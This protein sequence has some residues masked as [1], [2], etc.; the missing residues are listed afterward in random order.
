MPRWSRELLRRFRGPPRVAFHPDY[1]LPLPSFAARTGADARRAELALDA[2]V[3]LGVIGHDEVIVPDPCRWDDLARV[4]TPAWLDALA[5]PESLAAVFAAEPAEVP[6]TVLTS[7]RRVTGGTIAAT[8]AAIAAGGPAVNLGGGFHH[9]RRDRGVAY[10]AVNDVA[11]AVAVARAEGFDGRVVVLD[12]DAHPP[13]GIADCLGGTAWI[14]SVSGERW[15]APPG[16]QEVVVPPGVDDDAYLRAVDA[17]LEQVPNFD[18]AFVVA[19]GDVL[20]GDRHGGLGVSLAGLRRRDEMVHRRLDG[21]PSVWLPAG[22]YRDDSWRV[23]AGTVLVVSGHARVEIPAR[24]DPLRARFERVGRGLGLAELGA[25]VQLTAADLDETL[26]RRAPAVPKLLG[27]YTAAGV[28]LA[29]ERYGILPAVRQLGYANLRVEVEAVELGDR[30]RVHGR[31]RGEEHLLAESVLARVEA[32]GEAWVFVHWLNMRHPLAAFAAD[33]PPLPGQ[34]VPGLGLAREA[35]EI[36][37]RM[38]ERLGCAGVRMR[39]SFLHV[40]YAA[41]ARM[42]FVDPVEQAEFERILDTY[43]DVSLAELSRRASAGELH[44]GGQPWTWRAGVMEERVDG[45][46]GVGG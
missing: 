17:L 20:A 25:T 43:R 33:R 4:H 29:L 3:E 23:L 26:G 11:V 40:A 10:C 15:P 28:E 37:R 44:L 5:R 13:D 38:A 27:T 1:R 6:E 34:N 14:G 2:L 45:D 36:H 31:A 7:V 41:R 18:L 35:F 46:P 16:V 24:L 9:A 12:F 42:R 39:P 21:R 22:G 8:R 19:G 30:F 32:D